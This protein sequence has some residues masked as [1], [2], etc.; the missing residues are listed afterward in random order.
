[1]GMGKILKKKY[2][3]RNPGWDEREVVKV[4]TEVN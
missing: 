1:M 4:K 3:K 2:D